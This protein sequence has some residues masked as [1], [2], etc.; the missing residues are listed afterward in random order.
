VPESGRSVGALAVSPEYGDHLF[1]ALNG[2]E[3]H[4]ARIVEHGGPGRKR[5][6]Q[7][8][9]RGTRRSRKGLDR[10]TRALAACSTP[11][12]LDSFFAYC[13]VSVLPCAT[14]DRH[15]ILFCAARTCAIF[16]RYMVAGTYIRQHMRSLYSGGS[17]SWLRYAQ[18]NELSYGGDMKAECNARQ[19]VCK[20]IL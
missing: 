6:T 4:D 20:T 15:R 13:L 12:T 1:G 2:G 10:S 14:Y 17:R 7:W 18:I 16:R 9:N 5:R 3:R 11:L 8:R 19:R